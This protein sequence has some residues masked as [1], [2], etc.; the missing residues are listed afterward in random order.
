LIEKELETEVEIL[1]HEKQK[2]VEKNQ[3]LQCKLQ[4]LKVTNL[5]MTPYLSFSLRKIILQK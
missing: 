4:E 3:E 2:I 5:I 1:T